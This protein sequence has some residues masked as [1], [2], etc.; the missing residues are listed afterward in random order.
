M[1][2]YITKR[3]DMVDLLCWK[4]YGRTVKTVEIVLDANPGLAAHGPELPAGLTIELPVIQ[5]APLPVAT[6]KLW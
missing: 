4:K 5:P 6:I 2:A 1:T 3:G